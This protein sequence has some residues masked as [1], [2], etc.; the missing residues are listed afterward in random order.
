MAQLSE[1]E[2]EKLRE[3]LESGHG[4]DLR[5]LLS[6]FVL[7]KPE[8]LEAI[9]VLVPIAKQVAD[10]AEYRAA[11]KLVIGKWKQAI[12]WLGSTIAAILLLRDYILSFLGISAGVN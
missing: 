3:I 1:R 6:N 12:M 11:Q 9:K 8:D 10:E 5:V 2:I 7:L 4:E